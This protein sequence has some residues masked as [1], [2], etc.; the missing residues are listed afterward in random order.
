MN[1]LFENF[2][3]LLFNG[4]DCH[5]QL[6]SMSNIFDELRYLILIMN[7]ILTT[8]QYSIKRDNLF[9]DMIKDHSIQSSPII[10]GQTR[11]LISHSPTSSYS[12]RQIHP[13]TMERSKVSTSSFDNN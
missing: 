7:Q 3:D 4:N 6:K 8:N 12:S 9:S 10:L 13:I 5:N 11:R 2:K 1:K